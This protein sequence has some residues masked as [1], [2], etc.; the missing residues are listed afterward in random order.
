MKI[1]PAMVTQCDNFNGESKEKKKSFNRYTYTEFIHMDLVH[2]T[3]ATQ[4]YGKQFFPN[5]KS[6]CFA[7]LEKYTF[8]VIVPV[9]HC[10]I[11]HPPHPHINFHSDILNIGKNHKYNHKYCITVFKKTIDMKYK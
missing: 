8:L 9:E 11:Y 6:I 4:I 1:F 3:N 10:Q 7:D 5:S 2:E